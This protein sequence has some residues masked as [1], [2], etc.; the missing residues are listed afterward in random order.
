MKIYTPCA[1]YIL[2]PLMWPSSGRRVTKCG[3]IE[4]LKKVSELLHRCKKLGFE[5]K[6]FKI[7][8]F[9]SILIIFRELLN[10]I[11]TY[12]NSKLMHGHEYNKEI[13]VC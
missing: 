6:W 11:K 12:M 9:R 7:H 8:M 5:N 1:F 3:Y 4:I 10:I 13:F 2:R